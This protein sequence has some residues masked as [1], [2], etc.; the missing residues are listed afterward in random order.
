MKTN[1]PRP[2][3]REVWI[4]VQENEGLIIQAFNRRKEAVAVAKQLASRRP[5]VRTESAMY[6]IALNSQRFLPSGH[7]KNKTNSSNCESRY[8]AAHWMLGAA[9]GCGV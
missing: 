2:L 9:V 8:L 5:S 7:P 4:V 6:L 1:P 3:L